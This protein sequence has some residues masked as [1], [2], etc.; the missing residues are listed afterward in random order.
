MARSKG[1]KASWHLCTRK[2]SLSKGNPGDEDKALQIG[3]YLK[4]KG[5][6]STFDSNTFRLPFYSPVVIESVC[7]GKQSTFQMLFDWLQNKLNSL[8][9]EHGK[10]SNS[11]LNLELLKEWQFKSWQ[12]WTVHCTKTLR[13]KGSKHWGDPFFPLEWTPHLLLPFRLPPVSALQATINTLG[14][15]LEFGQ[16]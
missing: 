1:N 15:Y 13:S 12:F 6:K 16:L 3:F 5:G 10:F 8:K 14:I 11:H 4:Y 2:P 9:T 7:F